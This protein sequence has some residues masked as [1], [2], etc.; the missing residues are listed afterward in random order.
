M[1]SYITSA[2]K[3]GAAASSAAASPKINAGNDKLYSSYFKSDEWTGELISQTVDLATGKVPAYDPANPDASTYNWSAQAL[4][5]TKCLGSACAAT[6][7]RKIYTKGTI[8]GVTG[9]IDFD[10]AKLVLAGLDG[11]FKVPNISSSPPA[12]PKQLTGLSQ[13]CV[14]SFTCLSAAAQSNFTLATSGAG[15]EALV[16]FLRGDR[17]NEEGVLTDPAKFYRHRLHVLGDIVSAEP[18]YVAASNLTYDEAL[19]PGYATFKATNATRAAN[20]YTAAN[21]GMLHAFDAT[22]GAEKWAYIPSFVLPRLYT[23][24]DKKYANKHQYF[25]EGTPKV[26]DVFINSQWKTILVAGLSGG[27]TGFYALDVTNPA[28]PKFLWEFTDDDMGY[29]FGNPVITKQNDG[30]WVV[31]LTSGYDNC[32]AA[33]AINCA[34]NGVGDGKGHL[35]VFKAETGTLVSSPSSDIVTSAG[36]PTDP[37]GLSKVVAF[38]PID[39]VTNRAYAG[40]LLGNL[41][42]FVIT[43]SGYDKQLLATFKDADGNVQPVTTK[44][45]V[46]TVSGKTVVYVGTGRYLGT[47]DVGNAAAQSFYAVKDT[48]QTTSYG[49]P[50]DTSAGF[51]QQQAGV[52][53][54]PA[55]NPLTPLIDESKPY[56]GVCVA[57]EKIRTVS[58]VSGDTTDSLRNKN[59]WVLD[60]PVGA[61]EMSFTDPAIYSG[62]LLFSTSVATAGISE[63]CGVPTAANPESYAYKLNYLTGGAVRGQSGVIANVLGAGIATSPRL[64]ELTH[65]DSTTGKTTVTVKSE[66]TLSTGEKVLLEPPPNPDAN[67]IKRLSWT[68]DE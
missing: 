7:N 51:I 31:L 44:P 6:T 57:G 12:F 49:N 1:L 36:S 40:D 46:T 64:F 3:A 35:F 55:D 8:A 58:L 48:G 33:S 62:T 68:E 54:C 11:N 5:D 14:T 21:D 45:V 37:S 59:G 26:A 60:F 52:T 10:W 65:T 63:L 41:W 30:T 15:G 39:N 34:K 43:P 66:T 27:G 4:L 24:A 13:F 18:Q 38:A 25:V 9:L 67:G 47:S 42:R 29:S 61:K 2:S 56:E 22:T 20:I 50:R 16:N 53:T 28:N 23:L 17:S 19:N 32:P